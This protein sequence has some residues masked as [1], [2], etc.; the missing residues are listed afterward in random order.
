M[1]VTPYEI[2]DGGQ[3]VAVIVR[4]VFSFLERMRIYDSN[5]ISFTGQLD[6]GNPFE[7]DYG[8]FLTYNDNA[9]ISNYKLVSDSQGAISAAIIKHHK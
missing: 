5:K 4:V 6:N 8:L 1:Q 3:K 7:E 2:V 9:K